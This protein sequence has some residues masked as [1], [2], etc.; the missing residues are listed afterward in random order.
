MINELSEKRKLSH[1]LE[2][3]V[4]IKLSH[5]NLSVFYFN[6]ENSSKIEIE[7]KFF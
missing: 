6:F 5:H 2:D 3:N 1:T 4:K 7:Q